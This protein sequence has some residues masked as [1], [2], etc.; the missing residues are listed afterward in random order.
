MIDTSRWGRPAYLV[1]HLSS[2]TRVSVTTTG[3]ALSIL[4]DEAQVKLDAN[5]DGL[6]GWWTG[7]V[8]LP[9]TVAEGASAFVC[10][11]RGFVQK[12]A[13]T[14]ALLV[15]SVAGQTVTHDLPYGSESEGEEIS[16]ELRFDARPL[17]GG[18]VVIILSVQAERQNFDE[19]VT[20]ACDSADAFRVERAP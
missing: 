19:R 4:F 12:T 20:L 3:D 9:L 10:H 14:R 17:T 8:L 5:E 13:G 7:G 2:S 15:A 11:L 16:L 1:P 18:R 6:E